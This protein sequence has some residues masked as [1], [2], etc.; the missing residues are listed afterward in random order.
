MQSRGRR[1][2]YYVK[3][4]FGSITCMSTRRIE[5]SFYSAM[6][7]ASCRIACGCS[8]L[9]TG[10]ASLFRGRALTNGTSTNFGAATDGESVF[11]AAYRAIIHKAFVVG[12]LRMAQITPKL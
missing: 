9:Q 8:T 11:T 7:T 6:S 3:K 4:S 5:I 10:S 12:V 2:K 1:K